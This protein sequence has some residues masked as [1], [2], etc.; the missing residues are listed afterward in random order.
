MSRTNS[1]THQELLKILSYNPETG[2][3]TWVI[4][5]ANRIQIGAVA[6]SKTKKGYINIIINKVSYKAHRLAWLYVYGNLPANEIDH[7]NREKDDNR[8]ENLRLATRAQQCQNQNSRINSSTGFLGV[9][10]KK[11]KYQAAIT[12]NGVKHYLGSFSSPELAHSAYL[13][14]KASLHTFNP[15]PL[16]P[17]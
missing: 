14:A 8:L 4:R 12:V 3:F 11:L 9:Y 5:S 17:S 15:T 13:L 7:I 16:P 10:K 6:G 1:I 2:V